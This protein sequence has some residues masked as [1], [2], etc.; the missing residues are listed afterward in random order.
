[1][2]LSRFLSA[3]QDI[4]L[5]YQPRASVVPAVL[6]LTDAPFMWPFHKQPL[7]AGAMPTMINATVL[8]GMS[9]TGDSTFWS[10]K[11]HGCQPVHDS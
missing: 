7:Y 1:M 8:N 9:L 10:P 4:L 2:T 5:S 11:S 6:D 3:A